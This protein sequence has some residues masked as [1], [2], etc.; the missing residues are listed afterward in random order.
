MSEDKGK[1]AF[2]AFNI[3]KGGFVTPDEGTE[4]NLES[5][6]VEGDPALLNDDEPELTDVEKANKLKADK[7]LEEVAKK[8]EKANKKHLEIVDDEPDT[9]EEDEDED[10]PDGKTDGVFSTFIKD[11]AEKNILDVDLESIED[12]EEFVETA[13]EET[14]NKRFE[15]LLTD[16]LGDD[17][18]KLLSFIEAGG[19][20]RQFIN[21]FY[22]D[23]TWE[24][25]DIESES[26]QKVAIK[27][28]LRLDGYSPED[29]EDMVTE[30]T[31]LGSLKKRAIP[32]LNKLKRI[33]EEQKNSL[34]TLQA[35]KDKEKR[36]AQE[37]YWNNFKKDLETRD[38]IKGFKLTPKVKDNLYNFITVIDKKTGKTAYQEA[39]ANNNDASLMFAY[40]AMN[41]FDITKLERQVESKVSSK[42]AATLKNYKSS[43]KD[44]ISSGRTDVNSDGTD[45]FAGFKKL[46]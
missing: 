3:L 45:M 18:I 17:G 27:E 24:E 46:G 15:R 44:K 21:T 38:D 12:T 22:S 9:D 37:N 6:I 8:Q 36:Q 10:E 23:H 14:V 5:D 13:V 11:L 19:D 1:S 40:L 32:A 41:K 28:A 43:G 30:W 2:E 39:L 7:A 31:E 35:E 42:L 16:K 25:F 4:P 33:E 29:V 26:A 34:L 20:P